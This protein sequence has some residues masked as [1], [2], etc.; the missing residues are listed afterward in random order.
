MNTIRAVVTASGCASVGEQILKALHHSSLPFH[1][2]ACD[3][4]PD[5][6][7]A[8]LAD[9]FLV[10][11]RAIH[12]HYAERM[13]TICRTQGADVLFIGSEAELIAISPH[14]AEFAREGV[15]LPLQPDEVLQLCLDKALLY[16][17]LNSLGFFTPWYRRIKSLSDLSDIPEFPL[18]FKPSKQSGGSADVY[19][20][21]EQNELNFFSAYLL[22][23]HGEFVAQ[24][25]VGT[26]DDE[27]T[28][29]VL[30]DMDSK[31]MG[32]I[33]LHRDLHTSFS[34][35]LKTLN[36]TKR[37]ELGELLIV[38]S[39]ISQGVLGA[40][41]HVCT[42]SASIATVL[43]GRGPM[44]I[45]CRFV[46]GKLCLLEINPRF[47]GTTSL[48]ALGGWNEP[49]MLVRRHILGEQTMP[50]PYTQTVRIGRRLE[51]VIIPEKSSRT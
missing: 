51:E 43:R 38:S 16:E 30:Q 21:R 12:P 28:V 34:R 4:T 3:C 25:Y 7:G 18:I 37:R 48:R 24:E 39:G 13:L 31:L 44:N 36:T 46:G 20:V 29:G 50:P 6:T 32:S 5:S 11:P 22:E 33:A 19:I 49:E 27:F 23:R 41:P 47:S 40:F 14:R 9:D 42:P 26:P 1:C 17:K 45:Q 35:H 8:T 10:V 2:I 15:F